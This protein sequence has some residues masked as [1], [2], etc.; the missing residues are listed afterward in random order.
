MSQR[1]KDCKYR[2]VKMWRCIKCRYKNKIK[3][4]EWL[5]M[6]KGNYSPIHG[7]CTFAMSF[8]SFMHSFALHML[9]FSLFP[10]DAALGSELLLASYPQC[11]ASSHVLN[12]TISFRPLLT[13]ACACA[14]KYPF[15]L[16]FTVAT[17]AAR[18]DSFGSADGPVSSPCGLAASCMPLSCRHSSFTS[19]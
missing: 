11:A 9:Q 17:V 2:F 10:Y 1:V 13:C 18:W 8:A 3:M 7:I 4:Q 12:K 19:R 6:S 14:C 15:L 5:C 16:Q